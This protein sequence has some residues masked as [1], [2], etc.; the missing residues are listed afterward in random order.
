[1]SHQLSLAGRVDGVCDSFLLWIGS[2]LRHPALAASDPRWPLFRTGVWIILQVCRADRGRQSLQTELQLRLSAQLLKYTKTAIR[3]A[4]SS[5]VLLDPNQNQMHMLVRAISVADDCEMVKTQPLRGFAC[6][7]SPLRVR[8]MLAR[9]DRKHQVRHDVFARKVRSKLAKRSNFTQKLRECLGGQ[10]PT[11]ELSTDLVEVSGFRVSEISHQRSRARSG[12]LLGN[13][14][15][16]RTRQR[17]SW[18]AEMRSANQPRSSSPIWN[19]FSCL[20]I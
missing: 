17:T 20:A 16:P 6:V 10:R 15:S 11:D 19:W 9:R 1:M 8:Q 7:P 5:A 12:G 2:T 3:H 13:H 14:R 18:T 4:L